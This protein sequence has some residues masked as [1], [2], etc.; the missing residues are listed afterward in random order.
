MAAGATTS[1]SWSGAR[2]PARNTL[3]GSRQGDR[4]LVTG[5]SATPQRDRA[6]PRGGLIGGAMPVESQQ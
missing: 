3:G 6:G 2:C 1:R 4:L 5:F